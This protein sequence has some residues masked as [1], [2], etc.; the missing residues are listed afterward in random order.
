MFAEITGESLYVTEKVNKIELF[1][2]NFS[3]EKKKKKENRSSKELFS[4][5]NHNRKRTAITSVSASGYQVHI[6]LGKF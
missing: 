2:E 4:S 1:M 3:P 6:W 5:S